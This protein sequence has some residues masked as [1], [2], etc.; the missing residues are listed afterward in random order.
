VS[1]NVVKFGDPSTG[2][3]SQF[4]PLL[5]RFEKALPIVA[6]WTI[7]DAG[8]DAISA[9]WIRSCVVNV[10]PASGEQPRLSMPPEPTAGSRRRPPWACPCPREPGAAAPQRRVESRLAAGISSEPRPVP[11]DV[12][13]WDI[14]SRQIPNIERGCRGCAIS[15]NRVSRDRVEDQAAVGRRCAFRWRTPASFRH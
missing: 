14:T 2:L 8:S 4:T 9:L 15:R 1:S 10:Q 6:L 5:P 12:V 11:A 3:K 7:S 13:R